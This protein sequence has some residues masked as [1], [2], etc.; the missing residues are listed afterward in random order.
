MKRLFAV[1]LCLTLLLGSV[2]VLAENAAL[3]SVSGQRAN[4]S[5]TEA[6]NVIKATIVENGKTLKPGDT[7]H[8]KV[9]VDDR[10]DIAVA[11]VYV[12]GGT[13]GAGFH[14]DLKYDAVSDTYTGEY[15]LQETDLNGKYRITAIT[16]ADVHDNGTNCF[17]SEKF[18]GSFTLKGATKVRKSVTLKG[19]VKIKENGITIRDKEKAH[20]TIK[21]DEKYKDA[22]HVSLNFKESKRP[23][24]ETGIYSYDKKNST[25]FEHVLSS[26]DFLVN[27]KYTLV[28]ITLFDEEDREI[29]QMKV[30]GQYIIFKGGSDDHAAPVL[31]SVTLKEK[32]KTLTA[33]DTV[34]ISVKITDKSGLLWTDGYLSEEGVTYTDAD[35]DVS[36]YKSKGY[37]PF[38]LKYNKSTGKYEAAVKL[39]KHMGDA[40][41]ALTIHATDDYSNYVEKT[42]N[43]LTITYST[44]DYVDKGMKKFVTECFKATTGK[45]PTKDEVNEYGLPLA[46]GKKKAVNVIKIILKKSKLTG[47]AA[48][49]ALWKI[50]QGKTPTD[51]EKA[52]TAAA[53][54]SGTEKAIDSLNNSVFRQRCKE[55]GITAG[56][57]GNKE[58][59]TKVSS[60]DVSGGH[61]TLNGSK[62]TFAG[63]TDKNVKSLAI[64]DTVTA[65]GKTYKVTKIDGAA[66]K[67][68]KNLAGVTIGKNVTSIGE[69]AF[70]DCKKLKTV[71]INAAKLKTVGKDAFSGIQKK[72]AFKCPKKQ[73]DAYKKLIKPNAPKNAKFE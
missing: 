59:S 65:N 32:G 37:L 26:G 25:T 68:L 17:S 29:G 70:K 33:G 31:S 54:K 15:K 41:Y 57:F 16:V 63:V 1:I 2:T 60:V 69:S 47:E 48:A 18:S 45:K 30:S 36:V 9:K 72:A 12:W 13:D 7:V 19:T 58:A 43:N 22:H 67:G 53:L 6:P 28:S 27:D 35:N 23:E 46:N 49:E 42:F 8:I 11:N 50:M 55:W 62:A 71:T 20:V 39:P 56:N 14:V 40:V 38:D 3:N 4:V 5:D 66:C 61:Y 21:F 10:S 44:P 64:Q 34:H 52:K 24:Y 73:K 51:A